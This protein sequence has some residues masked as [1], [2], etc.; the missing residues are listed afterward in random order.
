MENQRTEPSGRVVVGCSLEWKAS[1]TGVKLQ[2]KERMHV[3]SAAFTAMHQFCSDNSK[4][5][6]FLLTAAHDYASARCLL[7]NGLVSGGLGAGAQ[8]IEKFLKAYILLKN[9]AHKVDE[10][11]HRLTTILKTVDRL[12]PSLGLSKFTALTDRFGR[13]YQSRYPD[14]ADASTSMSSEEI[15]AR[16]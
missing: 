2:D 10:L 6:H 8:A 15:F 9:P 11:R 14:N 12:S 7:L 3:S 13:H 16:R 5:T 1:R 4:A